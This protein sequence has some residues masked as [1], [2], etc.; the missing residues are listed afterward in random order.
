MQKQDYPGKIIS[1]TKFESSCVITSDRLVTKTI[2]KTGEENTPVRVIKR[3]L[4]KKHTIQMIS[5]LIGR[6]SEET[7]FYTASRFAITPSSDVN[8][9]FTNAI[10]D[11]ELVKIS[12]GGISSRKLGLASKKLEKILE[13][14]CSPI[15]RTEEV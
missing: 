6:A 14:Y 4:Q 12:S 13:S 8:A 3:Y 11:R 15:K 7:T 9:F 2:M 1:G 10:G 5:F